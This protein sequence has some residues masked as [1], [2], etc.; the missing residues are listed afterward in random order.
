M[1]ERESKSE[2]GNE[3]GISSLPEWALFQGLFETWSTW[4]SPDIG[5][6]F[7]VGTAVF[8]SGKNNSRYGVKRKQPV[9]ASESKPPAVQR[10]RKARFQLRRFRHS[11]PGD[12]AT[13]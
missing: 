4:H 13:K 12:Q 3:P 11:L 8:S 7:A 1:G 9:R 10:P 6:E 2:E 5:P